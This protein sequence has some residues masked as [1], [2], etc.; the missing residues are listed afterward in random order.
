MII[1]G[2][3]HLG[4]TTLARAV[5]LPYMHFTKPIREWAWDYV[6][7]YNAMPNRVWDRFHLGAL[8]YGLCLD[9]HYVPRD[10]VKRADAMNRRLRGQA[11]LVVIHTTDEDWY[12]HHLTENAKGEMFSRE[13]IMRANRIFPLAAP[14][15]AILIDI[16]DGQYSLAYDR[17]NLD[18]TRG[19]RVQAEIRPGT[20]GHYS[21]GDH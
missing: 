17:L 13:M 2:S 15:W 3:D 14:E 8:V 20:G 7:V 21:R 11:D 5:D 9:L 6:A 1:E 18:E 12:R 16:K 4:K 10:I 19:H